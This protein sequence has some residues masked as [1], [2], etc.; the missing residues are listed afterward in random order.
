MTKREE[1]ENKAYMILGN[2]A[3]CIINENQSNKLIAVNLKNTKQVVKFRL[4]DEDLLLQESSMSNE[5]TYKAMLI[6]E[7]NKVRLIK[8]L[9]NT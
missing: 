3:F 5:N 4:R 6:A 1:I 2:I 8:E 7:R 9:V